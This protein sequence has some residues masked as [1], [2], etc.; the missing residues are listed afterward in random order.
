MLHVMQVLVLLPTSQVDRN[1]NTKMHTER[2]ASLGD[3]HDDLRLAQVARAMRRH[4]H[5]YGAGAGVGVE[6]VHD[7]H[8][9]EPGHGHGHELGRGQEPEPE[10]EAPSLLKFFHD[11]AAI[12]ARR[13]GKVV[14]QRTRDE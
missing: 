1:T 6:P 7:R 9:G 2:I 4:G 12:F 11:L 14:L 3:Y 10:P 13:V 8:R 5:R